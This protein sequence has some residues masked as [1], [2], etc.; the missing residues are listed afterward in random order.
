MS[1]IE[2][3]VNTE[4]GEITPTARP[5]FPVAMFSPRTLPELM[6][7]ANLVCTS[8]L[9]PKEYKNKPGDIV[10][11]VMA[12]NEVGLAA[13][14]SLQSY[15]VINGRPGLFGDAPLAL[16][17]ASGK[18][19]YFDEKFEGAGDGLTAVCTAQRKGSSLHAIT[20]GVADARKAGLWGKAGPW[21]QYPQRMLQM[22]ARSWA[23]RDMF[24][25][26]LKGIAQAE[27]L[28]DMPADQEMADVRAYITDRADA[29]ASPIRIDVTPVAPD[30]PRA[31]N[32]GATVYRCENCEKTITKPQSEE[33]ARQFHQALCQPCAR[34]AAAAPLKPAPPEPTAAV[35]PSLPGDPFDGEATGE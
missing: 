33:T 13:L 22:R 7:F 32:G 3:E 26:V 28:I 15:C 25:D 1:V 35:Q 31:A 27:E 2:R 8:D 17:R 4:T 19:A 10:V 9:I 18:L 16:V 30:S 6:E 21:Q 34:K 12:G 11:A 29:P 14:Q 24:P 20:F 23:L 5:R